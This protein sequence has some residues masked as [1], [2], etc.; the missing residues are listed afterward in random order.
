MEGL[1]DNLR[2]HLEGID[3]VGIGGLITTYKT[4]C[5]II[6]T[7]RDLG[8]SGKIV[9]G[10]GLATSEYELLL[11]KLEIDACVLGEGEVAFK[12]L[13]EVYQGNGNACNAPSTAF[14]A[15]GK[16]NTTPLAPLIEDLDRLPFPAWDIFP[17]DTYLRTCYHANLA[18]GRSDIREMSMVSSRGCPYNCNF[19]YHLFGRQ[20]R[21][22]SASNILSEIH[23]LQD[24]YGAR[25]HIRFIDDCFVVDR[26]RLEEFCERMIQEKN[27]VT[28][29]CF[30]R[31]NLCTRSILRMMKRAG[32][33]Y[34]GYGLESG[35]DTI[36]SKVIG[37]AA[38]VEQNVTALRETFWAGMH[39]CPTAMVNQPGETAETIQDTVEM[40]R[41][42]EASAAALFFACPYPG[43]RLWTYAEEHGLIRWTREE[44]LT[45]LSDKDVHELVVNFTSMSDDELIRVHSKALLDINRACRQ[46]TLLKLVRSIRSGG[47]SMCLKRLARKN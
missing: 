32:C 27:R 26:P 2:A 6:R 40:L 13:V 20:Y 24:K 19:C 28:W 44:Y 31:T 7:I 37:K 23:A 45:L 5:H 30:G 10:G 1:G 42:T 46:P 4:Q 22:R 38:T 12:A 47:I 29:S 43:T 16:V 14:L 33:I 8:F 25:L 34:V 35:N 3:I 9:L 18:P 21:F 17:V 11:E 41:R 15:D 36:L 39:S